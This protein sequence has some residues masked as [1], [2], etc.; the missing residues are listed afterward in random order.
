[1]PPKRVI[2]RWSAYEHEHVP[3][4]ND[5]FWALGIVAV[6]AALTSILFH[7]FFFAILIVIAA[8]ILGMLANVPPDLE[9]FEISDRGIRV[10]EVM[11]AYEEVIS[12][13]VEEEH[14]DRPLLL[15]DTV[16]FM[17]PNLV[18]PLENIDPHVVRSYLRERVEEVPMR[19]P[20]A[21][22]ILEFFGL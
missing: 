5:W 9:R 10:G 6:S 11:H 3:R 12:F 14:G 18:I 19:E 13:W 17:A 1:M 4:G 7:D 20:F 16:K 15:V 22:K 21:H 8:A 2:L